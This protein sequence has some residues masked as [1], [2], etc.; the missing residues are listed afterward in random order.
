MMKNPQ[1]LIDNVISQNQGQKIQTASIFLEETL[2]HLLLS[3]RQ[4]IS[5][6]EGLSQKFSYLKRSQLRLILDMGWFLFLI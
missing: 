3:Y 4:I 5:A 1:N 2:Y 6:S